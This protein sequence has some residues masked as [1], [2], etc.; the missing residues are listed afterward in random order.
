MTLYFQR[1]ALVFMDFLRDHSLKAENSLALDVRA[2]LYCR[3]ESEADL[4][5]ALLRARTEGMPV[6]IL[7]G[8]SNLVLAADVAGLVVHMRLSGLQIVEQVGERV[9]LR[10]AAGEDWPSLVEHCLAQGHYGLENLSAIPGTAGAAPVQNIGAYGIELAERFVALE[11]LEIETGQIR[12]LDRA[13]CDFGYRTSIFKTS[14]ENRWAITAIELDLSRAERVQLDYQ[15]L[16][17][18]LESSGI[19]S[20]TPLDVHRAICRLRARRLPD[21]AE[22][23]NVGSFFKNP[24]V[25]PEKQASLAERFED[26]ISHRQADGRFKLAA[27]WLIEQCG[28]KGYRHGPVGMYTGQALVLVNYGG[29]SPAQVLELADRVR[30]TVEKTFG[31]AL[32]IE[33][34]LVG[35]RSLAVKE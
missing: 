19:A 1:V 27:G 25:G 6:L 2:D 16:A 17:D 18:E 10:V 5:E 26:L 12:R 33:P 15:A 32:E 21:P 3:V 11:A 13:A 30:A 29:A 8:G 24:V 4:T 7:G 20:P 31:L 14:Q 28:F 22:L 23:P 9:R 35:A 34:R